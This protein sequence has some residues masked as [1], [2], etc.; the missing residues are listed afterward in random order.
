MPLMRL[1]RKGNGRERGW[2]GWKGNK[3]R[4]EKRRWDAERGEFL[5]LKYRRMVVDGNRCVVGSG[6]GV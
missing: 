4:D 5:Q 3:R 1:R 6:E 2:G